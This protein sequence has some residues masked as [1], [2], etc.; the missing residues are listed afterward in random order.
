MIRLIL[1][2]VVAAL[3]GVAGYAAA[4]R[5]VA[6]WQAVG[7]VSAL[8]HEQGAEIGRLKAQQA[9]QW[10]QIEVLQRVVDELRTAPGGE[11]RQRQ[12]DARLKELEARATALMALV[13]AAEGRAARLQAGAAELTERVVALERRPAPGGVVGGVVGGAAETRRLAEQID[14]LRDEM[15]E[16]KERV[17][18]LR[19]Q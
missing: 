7:E 17:A 1:T 2:G 12:A 13:Q 6:A 14:Q 10:A 5:I 4:P 15:A 9:A 11:E 19:R 18:L 3:L 8:A 16:I